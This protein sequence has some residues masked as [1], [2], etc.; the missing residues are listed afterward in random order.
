MNHVATGSAAEAADKAIAAWQRFTDGIERSQIRRALDAAGYSYDEPT[1]EA[2]IECFSDYVDTG[3]WA[4][5]TMEDIEDISISEMC[6]A[7]IR[8]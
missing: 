5:L 4:D 6:R 2:L 1:K 3:A 8:M 7:L